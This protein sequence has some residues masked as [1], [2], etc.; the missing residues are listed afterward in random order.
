MRER[1][2]LQFRFE[3]LNTFNNVNLYLPNNDLALA[4]KAN[5]TFSSTSSFGKST[6]A[7]DPRIL[8]VSARLVF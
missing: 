3:A 1:A 4:L 7:F 8:Q 6:Q 5:G 2:V